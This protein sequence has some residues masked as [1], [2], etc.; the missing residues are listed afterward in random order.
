MTKPDVKVSIGQ[1]TETSTTLKIS[2][3]EA[4]IIVAGGA[5]LLDTRK[6]ETG[7]VVDQTE[8]RPIPTARDPWVILSTVPGVQLDRVNVG[9]NESGQQSTYVGKG[10]DASQNTWNVDGVTITD[11]GAL[12]SS[13][14]YYD[15]ESF[16]E[17]QASTGGS[18]VT[19]A[20]PGVQLNLVTKRGTND[21]HGSARYYLAD[22]RPRSGTTSRRATRRRA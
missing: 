11:M 1:N 15:F 7:A 13:P 8:L 4:T 22:Q 5:A 3:V 19:A 16:E 20:T 2:S 18:D 12:G 21:V 14:T 6:V 9:G 10:A 17:I